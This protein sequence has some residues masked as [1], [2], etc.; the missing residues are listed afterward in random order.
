MTFRS[1]QCDGFRFQGL[2]QLSQPTGIIWLLRCPFHHN[3]KLALPSPVLD[4]LVSKAMPLHLQY[5]FLAS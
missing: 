3:K 4:G 5:T 1:P 2:S